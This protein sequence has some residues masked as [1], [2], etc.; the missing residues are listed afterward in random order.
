MNKKKVAVISG[1]FGRIGFEISKKLLKK[2]FIVAIIEKNFENKDILINQLNNYGEC[3]F[4]NFDI[5]KKA[6]CKLVIEKI[7]QDFNSIDYLINNAA[8]KRNKKY[9]KNL[10]VNDWKKQSETIISGTLYLS[11]YAYKYLKHSKNGSIVNMSSV[12]SNEVSNANCSWAYQVSKAGLNHLTKLLAERFGKESGVRV[13][14][15]APALVEK[16]NLKTYNI[17]N[18]QADLI[19]KIIPL[20]R[21]AKVS[22]IVELVFFLLSKKSSYITGQ[23]IVIDGGLGLT[24]HFELGASIYNNK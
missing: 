1:G 4:Y 17:N 6:N 9:L 5:S 10:L 16:K 2:N 23:V 11:N 18:E 7:Y 21:S 19:K 22:E 15:V 12:I 13:N 8:E 20:K 3:N 14:A 24:E